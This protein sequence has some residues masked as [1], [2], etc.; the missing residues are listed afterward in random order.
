MS[1]W[2][3]TA[4]LAFADERTRAARD[5]LAQV[6]LVSPRIVYD[7]G[8]GPGNS[9]TLLAARFPQARITGIDN[10]ENMLDAAR[11]ACP[12]SYFAF[13]DLG[14]WR[15]ADAPGLLFSNA[16]LQWVPDH[17]DVMARLLERLPDGGVLAVQMPDNLDEPSH[18][19]MRETA[20]QGLWRAKLES[21]ATSRGVLPPPSA[22]YARLKPLCRRLDIWHSIYNHPLQGP[23]GIVKWLSATALRPFLD[24]LD[25]DARARFLAAYE[26]RLA[27]AY[28]AQAGGTVLLRFP[29]L[30][31][32]AVR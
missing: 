14:H 20:E 27:E 9:T 5:L 2:D 31:V 13:G 28:P 32:V 29:R 24:P 12:S 18:R 3:P 16:A 17:L 10:S 4:Y 26:K 19:L 21:A 6:P 30:F 15:P 1:D 7:L 23:G 11:K 22:Y 8:C 25:D